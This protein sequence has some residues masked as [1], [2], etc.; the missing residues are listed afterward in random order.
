MK[1]KIIAW[2]L[3]LSSVAVS[4]QPIT[5]G[6]LEKLCSSSESNDRAACM[7]IT[8]VY[9]DGFLEGVGKGV[10]DTYRSD[11]LVFALVKDMNMR[12]SLPRVTKVVDSA[13]CIQKVSVSEMSKAFLEY[14]KS[15]SNLRLEHYKKSMTLA[16]VSKFCNK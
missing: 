8:K 1:T 4:A 14:V 10:I 7:L 11:P 6:D 5:A 12:D 15:N 2:A 16:I 13:S 9:M 3:A